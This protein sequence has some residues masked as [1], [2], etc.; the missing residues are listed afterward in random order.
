MRMILVVMT[1]VV[2]AGGCRKVEFVGEVYPAT[3]HVD[4]YCS[5]QDVQELHR[6]IGH[7]VPVDE[8]MSNIPK[9]RKQM[10]QAARMKGADA[11]VIVGAGP[12][13]EG[14][15][16]DNKA[17]TQALR[18]HQVTVSLLRYRTAQDNPTDSAEVTSAD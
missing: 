16:S 10:L 6:V 12:C 18:A 14:V 11:L 5:W 3:G 2:L 7:F 17:G 4:L 13:S 15:D 9:M 1:A 8:D